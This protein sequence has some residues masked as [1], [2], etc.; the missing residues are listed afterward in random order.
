MRDA[1]IAKYS[2]CYREPGYRQTEDRQHFVREWL[3]GRA[4]SLL[5]VGTGRGETLAIARGLGYAPVQGTEVVPY[6]VTDGVVYAEAHALPFDDDSFD[7]VTCFDVLEHLLYEDQAPALREFARVAS[8]RVVV[9]AANYPTERDGVQLHVGYR[10]NDDWEALI[11]KCIPGEVKRLG[12]CGTAEGWS[13]E[14][15]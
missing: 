8:A 11:R 6:L 14:L 2:V 15:K 13:V 9:T 12:W 1:E 3:T 5:D 10:D 4:G 7:T